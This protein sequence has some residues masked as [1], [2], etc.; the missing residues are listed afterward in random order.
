MRR[1]FPWGLGQAQSSGC[2]RER[3]LRFGRG[4]RA[5]ALTA[6]NRTLGAQGFDPKAQA[7]RRRE[8]P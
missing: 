7:R 3:G 1:E 2:A 8:S 4:P 6:R 5:S